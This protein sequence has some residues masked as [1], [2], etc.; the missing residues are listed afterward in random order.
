MNIDNIVFLLGAGA[1]KDAGLKTSDEMTHEVELLL[2]GEWQRYEKLYNAVKAGIL[3]GYALK[4]EPKIEVN[5]EEFVNVL[6]ELSQ[7]KDHTVFPFIA[8]WNMELK[9]TAGENFGKIKEFRDAIIQVLVNEWVNLPDPQSAGYYVGLQ[10]F[11]SS[12]GSNLRVFSLNYDVCVESACGRDCV[13]TGFSH[14]AGRNCGRVWNDKMMRDDRD[15]TIPIRLYKLHGSVDWREESGSIVSY[16]SPSRCSDAGAYRLIFGTQNKLRYTDPYLVL[17]SEFRKFAADA[18]IIIC[19][20]YNFQDKHINTILH[21]AFT[22][23][24]GTKILVVSWA[25]E[26]NRENRMKEEK[27]RVAKTLAMDQE[28]VEVF[29][30]GAKVFME[31]D[32]SVSNIESMMPVE[33]SPF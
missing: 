31:R 30:E 5:I 22:K 12:L 17:L 18:K 4:G 10:R 21:S 24:T 33:D 23:Q 32:L 9:E 11:A 25:A 2:K 16:D 7:C 1:S 19:I 8:S 27:E 3:Y 13:F 29:L 15:H 14:V 28:C 6:T 20:G 26:G